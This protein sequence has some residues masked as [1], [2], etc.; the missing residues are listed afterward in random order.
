MGN[1]VDKEGNV[2][3]QDKRLQ[4]KKKILEDKQD[5]VQIP[6]VFRYSSP[7]QVAKDRHDQ[8]LK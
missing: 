7:T 1:L 3:N 6:R 4:F 8:R 2:L 5:L